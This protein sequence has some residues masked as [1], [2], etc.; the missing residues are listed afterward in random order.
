MR[1]L[2]VADRALDPRRRGA[3]IRWS[4]R[5]LGVAALLALVEVTPWMGL[6]S[7]PGALRLPHFSFLPGP[8]PVWSVSVWVLWGGSALQLVLGRN[9][10]VAAAGTSLAML[11][12]LATD[13]QW[14]SN[15]VYLQAL[16]VPLVAW[17]ETGSG[18]SGP[19][20]D[21]R[22]G[23]G[24][25]ATGG[26]ALRL[27]KIQVCL[28]YAFAGL[29]KLNAEFLS[30]AVLRDFLPAPLAGET[31]VRAA[32]VATPVTE[33]ALP[34]LLLHPATRLLGFGLGAVLHAG[35]LL[36]TVEWLGILSFALTMWA[37]YPLFLI[38]PATAAG[39]RA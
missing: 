19:G 12:F 20:R 28:V 34:A 24:T 17:A 37:C 25:G 23:A 30:G 38:G 31:M 18:A 35:M 39:R 26:L 27:A 7:R 11:L 1:L 10:R 15:H 3:L 2:S 5:G 22:A 29:A 9:T 21:R 14:Y 33:L 32:A 8:G 16:L 6:L 13:R 36:Y 4:R